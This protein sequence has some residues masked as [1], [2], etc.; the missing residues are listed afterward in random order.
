MENFVLFN[1][2]KSVKIVNKITITKNYLINF[3]SAFCKINKVEDK[4]SVLLYYDEKDSKIGIEFKDT[5]D[6][7]GFKIS[8]TSGGDGGGYIAARS[9]FALNG[10]LEKIRTGRYSYEVINTDFKSSSKSNSN[11]DPDSSELFVIKL[12]KTEPLN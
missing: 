11:S 1:N 3:P 4:K 6:K 5:L 10:L 12:E 8:K 2:E 7:R 9:F